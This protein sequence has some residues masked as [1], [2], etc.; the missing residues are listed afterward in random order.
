MEAIIDAIVGFAKW[1]LGLL[2]AVITA[3]WDFLV[4]GV[5]FVLDQLLSFVVSLL[6]AID[7]SAFSGS[8]AAWGGLPSD[9]T[10]II[11]LVG[12]GDCMKVIA[13]AIGIRLVLQLIPFTRLGS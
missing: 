1:I 2:K 8:L 13:A 10:N 11:G 6:Q 9:V 5:A 3:V 4:D 7:V 12:L